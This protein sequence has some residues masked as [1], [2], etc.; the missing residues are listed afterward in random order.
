MGR[1]I[2]TGRGGIKKQPCTGAGKELD[3]LPMGLFCTAAQ[4]GPASVLETTSGE[5][6]TVPSQR[7]KEVEGA[8]QG[9][10]QRRITNSEAASAAV[11]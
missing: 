6:C 11:R 7:P 9:G 5:S 8:A 10:G 4:C 2:K 3:L 1:E